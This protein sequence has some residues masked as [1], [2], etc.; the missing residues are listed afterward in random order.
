MAFVAE[1][2]TEL[3]RASWQPEL[4]VRALGLLEA[5]VRMMDDPRRRGDTGVS[6][7][8]S[9]PGLRTL[10]HHMICLNLARQLHEAM[11]AATGRGIIP[12]GDRAWSAGLG[13]N[14][15]HN[16][17]ECMSWL[18]SILTRMVDAILGPFLH[19]EFQ[20]LNEN[21][22]HDYSRPSMDA[23]EDLFY[24]GHGIETLYMVRYSTQI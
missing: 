1:G 17:A 5:F 4:L 11:A 3:F 15:G 2:M 16:A 9:Y 19:P 24:L 14:E 6:V 22:A 13:A 18:E 12:A 23:N 8:T 21:L 7:G 10:G 20:L